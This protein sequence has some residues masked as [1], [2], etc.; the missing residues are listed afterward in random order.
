MLLA[1]FLFTTSETEL[2]CYH[3]KR[4]YQLL[5]E[6]PNDLKILGHYDISRKNPECLDQMVSTQKPNPEAFAKR[7]GV[8]PAFSPNAG[9]YGPEK[10]QKYRHIDQSCVNNSAVR[11]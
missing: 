9:K 7:Y 10:L 2:D 6:L 4:V 11:I 8:P 1:K 5:N 3:Q